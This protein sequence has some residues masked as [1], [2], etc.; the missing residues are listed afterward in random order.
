MELVSALFSA[1]AE[2]NSGTGIKSTEL[3]LNRKKELFKTPA[4]INPLE[5]LENNWRKF[6]R[7]YK[8][9]AATKREDRRQ[10]GF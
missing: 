9:W 4:E 6:K 8:E 7:N 3:C 5:N 10:P 2:P 1:A